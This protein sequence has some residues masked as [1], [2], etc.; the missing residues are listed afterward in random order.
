MK[1][2]K[3]LKLDE[4]KITKKELKT[5]GGGSYPKDCQTYTQVSGQDQNSYDGEDAC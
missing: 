1:K 4:F 3:E 2:L 5:I